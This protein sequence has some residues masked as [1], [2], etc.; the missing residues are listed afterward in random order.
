[1]SWI[2]K[3]VQIS[4]PFTMLSNAY[5]KRFLSRRLN[6]EIG[7]DAIAL[8]GYSEDY[9]RKIAAKLHG[10]GLRITMHTPFMDLS[11]GSPDP[12]ILNVTRHRL[13]QFLRLMP[14]FKPVQVVCHAGYDE[15]RYGAL[16][17]SW[18]TRSLKTW[19]WFAGNVRSEGAGLML[20]NV[21]EQ[22]PQEVMPLL[23]NLGEHGVGFC[24]DTG[25]QA[26][27]GKVPLETWVK[28]LGVLIGQLHL[29]DNHGDGDEHLALGKGNIEFKWLLETLAAERQFPPLITLEPHKEEDLWPSLEYLGKNWPWPGGV[30]T[31]F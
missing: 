15:K 22:S 1:M 12:A 19:K 30:S 27:F 4:I 3:Q 11:M 21:Y 26:V 20:E 25:H 16:K 18:L 6:P 23:D 13:E 17:E 10:R 2:A 5:L 14:L 28:S 7:F 8:D 24:L 9:F 31:A 29:H